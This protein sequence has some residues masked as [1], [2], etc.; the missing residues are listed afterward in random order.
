MMENIVL[1]TI[2]LLSLWH[3]K[4]FIIL[5]GEISLPVN[6]SYAIQMRY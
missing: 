3:E 2:A 4:A 6:M 1:D 5:Y